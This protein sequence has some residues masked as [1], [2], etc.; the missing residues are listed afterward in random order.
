LSGFFIPVENMPD[1]IQILTYGNPLRYF[2]SI[3]RAIY[4]KGSELPVLLD[5]IVGM[6]TIALITISLAIA[7]LR[8]R[9]L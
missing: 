1:A 9:S 5:E 8:K 6:S 2:M 7:R 3:I 4:Q